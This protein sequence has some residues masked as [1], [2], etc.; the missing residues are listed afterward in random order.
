[1]SQ[2]AIRFAEREAAQ[3]RETCLID[4]DVQ[5]GDV[6][7]QLGLQPKLSLAELLDAG[8]GSMAIWFAPRPPNIRAA[9]R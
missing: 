2:L 3:G 8:H 9:S 4:L 6:A 7:F 5:F 1:M